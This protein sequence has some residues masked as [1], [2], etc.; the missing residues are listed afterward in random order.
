MI[1]GVIAAKVSDNKDPDGQHRMRVVLA[2]GSVSGWIPYSV[3][4]AGSEA[5]VW[6]LPDVDTQVL[7][8]VL[9]RWGSGMV[10]PGG[11]WYEGLPP[12]ETGENTLHFI[13]EIELLT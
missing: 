11:F 7:V 8:A 1:T 9:D 6:A 13:T 5:G 4:L 12:P 10:A 3:P 2:N